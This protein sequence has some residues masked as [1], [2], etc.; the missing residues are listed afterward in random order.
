MKI[1]KVEYEEISIH[2][3]AEKEVF[4]MMQKYTAA[5]Y[6]IAVGIEKWNGN[7]YFMSCRKV[8]N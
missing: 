7:R 3:L 6:T 5:G 1:T 2:D 8:K 4:S